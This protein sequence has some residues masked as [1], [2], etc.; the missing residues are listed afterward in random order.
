MRAWIEIGP[1]WGVG[2]LWIAALTN[3]GYTVADQRN[4]STGER[5]L[6]I[7]GAPEPAPGENDARRADPGDDRPREEAGR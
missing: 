3:A 7:Q 2:R 1:G 6:I 5:R 4:L